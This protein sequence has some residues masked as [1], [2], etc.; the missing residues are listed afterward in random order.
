MAVGILH[1]RGLLSSTEIFGAHV[2]VGIL[3]RKVVVSKT[4]F[5]CKGC[6]SGGF[7]SRG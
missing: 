6:S 3:H 1:C 4:K 2:A 7:A 5:Y